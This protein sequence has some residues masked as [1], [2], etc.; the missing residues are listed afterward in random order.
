[1][2]QN[3]WLKLLGDVVEAVVRTALDPKTDP[4]SDPRSDQ[5]SDQRTA[6]RPTRPARRALPET[7]GYPGDF[8]GTVTPV[9]RPELDGEPDP[10]EVVWSWVPYEEDHSQGK[11]RPVLIVGNDGPW[12]LAL[13]LTSQ[14]HDRDAQQEARAGRRWM[15][16]GTGDWDRSGR[17]SEVRLN[18]VV[19]IHPDAVRREGAVLDKAVFDRVVAA[20]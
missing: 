7:D 19:R 1:M 3:P 5:R 6:P 2:T 16:I 15:D 18:R 10:G 17:P 20:L 8:V 12:L 13:Q 14:D 4:K 9:Y 11:D